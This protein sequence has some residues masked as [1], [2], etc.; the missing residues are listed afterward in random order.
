MASSVGEKAVR[1]IKSQKVQNTPPHKKVAGI[2][3]IGLAVF[4]INFVRCGT[5]IPTKDIGP[6][7]AITVADK[8]LEKTMRSNRYNLIFIP[9]LFA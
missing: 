5:A 6:A 9:I 4:I 1:A 8:I 3:I 7:K 2:I